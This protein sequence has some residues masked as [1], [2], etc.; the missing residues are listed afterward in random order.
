[1]Y[2]KKEIEDSISAGLQCPVT[3]EASFLIAVAQVYAT[4]ALVESQDAANLISLGITQ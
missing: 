1:M 3:A 2:Y 4:M